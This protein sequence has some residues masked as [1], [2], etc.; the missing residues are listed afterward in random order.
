MQC[1][2][3]T[4]QPCCPRVKLHFWCYCCSV[5][6]IT[7]TAQ[8]CVCPFLGLPPSYPVPPPSTG[9][10]QDLGGRVP[11]SRWTLHGSQGRAHGHPASPGLSAQQL[12]RGSSTGWSSQALLHSA[13]LWRCRG[14]KGFR[15]GEPEGLS[16]MGGDFILETFA[17]LIFS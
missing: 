6:S 7:I 11:C 13:P 9:H 2:T 8:L 12:P 16:H 4:R 17:S 3:V 15:W 1:G 10:C 5:A 14:Q